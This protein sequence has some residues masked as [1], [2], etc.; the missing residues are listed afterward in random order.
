MVNIPFCRF[1]KHFVASRWIC[2]STYKFHI[3][4]DNILRN[5]KY[6]FGSQVTSRIIDSQST[7]SLKGKNSKNR[8]AH[9]TAISDGVLYIRCSPFSKQ[10]LHWQV[11]PSFG[12]ASQGALTWN[13]QSY[14]V[15]T[16][17]QIS[18]ELWKPPLYMCT[19][20]CFAEHFIQ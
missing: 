9:W 11:K 7:I 17:A 13:S 14:Q 6:M 3:Y 19:L 5:I 8:R 18:E 10:M 2:L 12:F 16:F 4:L 20:L 1:G 15:S